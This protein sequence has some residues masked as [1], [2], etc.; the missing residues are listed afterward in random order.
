[1]HMPSFLRTRVNPVAM[2][3]AAIVLIGGAGV[4]TAATGG[5]LILGRSNTAATRTDLTNT[6][7]IP[8]GLHAEDGK[9][10]LMVNSGVKV[11]NL[12]ADR[13]DGVGAAAL[14]RRVDGECNGG[15]IR[16]IRSGGGV[17]CAALPRK[18]VVAGPLGPTPVGTF[19][20]VVLTLNCTY[21]ATLRASLEFDGPSG[22]V[23][24]TATSIRD[25]QVTTQGIG[26]QLHPE[27][28]QAIALDSTAE[29][30]ARQ[31]I[32]AMLER[33][34]RLTQFTFH[35]FADARDLSEGA[36]PCTVWGTAI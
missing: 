2:L 15:A 35:V 9:P 8:L 16:E 32:V 36:T 11:S 12:N 14:Q 10:P 25:G 4:G 13:L 30:Y 6:D 31:T 27:A 26:F 18:I 21:D 19:D 24:G 33:D 28:P 17:V 3:T 5:N 23:N 22:I 20:G 1:M 29:W 34:G 7:G